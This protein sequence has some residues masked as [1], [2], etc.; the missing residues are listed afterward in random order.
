ME[1]NSLENPNTNCKKCK[2]L[3]KLFSSKEKEFSHLKQ[4]HHRLQQ[5]LAEK[6]SE[7]IRAIRRAENSD[8]EL[9]KLKVKIQ[10]SKKLGIEK[11]GGEKNHK[12]T[13]NNKK[14]NYSSAQN[15]EMKHNETEKDNKVDDKMCKQ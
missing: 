12:S 6:G 3:Q 2:S 11:K 9:R 1:T 8:R 4:G 10:E 14:T 15:E 5:V 13:F 7:L